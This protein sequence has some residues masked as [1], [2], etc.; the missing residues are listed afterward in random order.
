LRLAQAEIEGGSSVVLDATFDHRHRRREAL[1]LAEDMDANIIFI[2]CTAKDT[3]LQSRLKKR[4]KGGAVSDARLKHFKQFKE[5]FE[6]LEDIPEGSYISVN[7]DLPMEETMLKILASDYFLLS[8]QAASAI[9]RRL[10]T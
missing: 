6:P 8:E 9:E 2:E 5:N 3:A 1:R 10:K 4:S 7:T